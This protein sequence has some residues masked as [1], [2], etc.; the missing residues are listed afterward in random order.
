MMKAHPSSFRDPQGFIFEQDGVLY[1]QVNESC[2]TSYE[3]LMGSGLYDELVAKQL[4]VPHVEVDAPRGGAGAYRILKPDLVP[5]ISYPYEWGFGQLKTAALTTLRIQRIALRHD[6]TL[7]DSSAFNVQFVGSR[8][9][10][11]DTLSF[12]SYVEGRPWV[13]Y[14]QF[15]QH[16]LAPLFLM[17]GCDPRLSV[18]SSNWIDGI[19]L[20][21]ARRLAPRRYRWKPGFLTHIYLHSKAQERFREATSRRSTSPR[22]SRASMTSILDNLRATIER[23][24]W[25]P[26]K[27]QWADY[28][29]KTNYSE[30]AMELKKRFVAS[31][32]DEI[33]PVHVVDLGANTGEFSTIAARAGAYV[34]ATDIDHGAVELCFRRTS[35][36]KDTSILPLVV[37]LT[38]PTPAVGWMNVERTS[39]LGRCS[40]K[41][42]LVLALALLHH[43]VI[44]NN[45]PLRSVIELLARTGTNGIV[46][47]VEKRDSQ[48]QRLLASREDIFDEYSEMGFENALSGIFRVVRKQPIAGAHRVMYH[49]QRI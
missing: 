21:V 37:D 28:Y 40:G 30:E 46:E 34:V 6:M 5:F 35:A 25:N 31:V 27:T 20:D 10:F 24:A 39:F 48:V 23:L 11:I 15:C 49:I 16:F 19:P 2:R 36:E 12:E 8:P 45:V 7:R 32:V 29:S 18:L 22:L 9:V 42:D 17:A 44:G 47:F 3:G 33:R 26:E 14:R 38:S 13:G 1:R 41:T 4:L 43:L